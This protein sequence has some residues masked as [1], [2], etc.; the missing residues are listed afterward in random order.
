MHKFHF[1]I[2]YTT[3]DGTCRDLLCAK[4]RNSFLAWLI[5]NHGASLAVKGEPQ[6]V[7]STLDSKLA[8]D[9]V[10]I[11]QKWNNYSQVGSNLSPL[12]CF[13]Y[14]IYIIC[15]LYYG[16]I[17]TLVQYLPPF[18]FCTTSKN[19]LCT[20]S[21]PQTLLY[22][23]QNPPLY[24]INVFTGNFLKTSRYSVNSKIQEYIYGTTTKNKR[25]FC[26]SKQ[27]PE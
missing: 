11:K 3:S 13:L 21:T 25:I 12:T 19:L 1:R 17:P 7:R 6:A 23:K 22:Y 24:S 9:S 26:K 14:T 20:V 8:H 15:L 2:L 10:V 18:F 27:T 5:V 16:Q 4:Y